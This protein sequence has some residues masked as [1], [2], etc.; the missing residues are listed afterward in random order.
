MGDAAPLRTTGTQHG[1]PPVR[2]IPYRTTLRTLDGE[3]FEAVC[4]KKTGC[5][6]HFR[7]DDER[8]GEDDGRVLVVTMHQ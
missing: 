4:F 8:A 5:D 2:E 7:I 6:L 3:E 1:K